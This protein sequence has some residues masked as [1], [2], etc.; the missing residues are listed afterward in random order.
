LTEQWVHQ[1]GITNKGHQEIKIQ[2][3]E[4]ERFPGSSEVIESGVKNGTKVA[5]IFSCEN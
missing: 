3:Q 1:Q 4:G 2:R 5:L